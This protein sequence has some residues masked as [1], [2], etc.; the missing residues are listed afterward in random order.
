MITPPK[1]DVRDHQQVKNLLD[2]E[3][4]DFMDHVLFHARNAEKTHF[5]DAPSIGQ[6]ATDW[7]MPSLELI[8]FNFSLT[9]KK[10][11]LL[12]KKQE[13]ALFLQFNY[14]RFRTASIQKQFS[15]GRITKKSA[16]ELLKW[17]SRV[18]ELRDRIVRF[19]LGLVLAMIKHFA[20]AAKLDHMEMISEG[21]MA[22]LRTVDKFDVSRN[23]KFSTY[24]CR[25]ILKAF[26]RIGLKQSR[27]RL[28]FP[29][30]VDNT[31]NGPSSLSDIDD[32]EEYA[33]TMKKIIKENK[34]G[35]DEREQV[36]LKLRFP[37]EDDRNYKLTLKEAGQLIGCSKERV[38]QI[39]LSALS[40]L[41]LSMEM[42]FRDAPFD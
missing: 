38:R 1:T 4:M 33:A 14:S 19:N 30:S 15:N 16:D 17:S 21:N 39:Q 41:R 25:A 27:Q 6:P 18:N 8:E 26:S 40:K 28:L 37:L 22:L 20:G 7:Y 31:V 13:R 11:K 32:L 35:L 3:P 2:G 29:V 23:F 42:L 5:C 12:N 9:T 24:A 34:A 10:N 36:V